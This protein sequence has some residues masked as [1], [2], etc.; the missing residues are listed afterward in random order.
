MAQDRIFEGFSHGLNLGSQLGLRGMEQQRQDAILQLQQQH[1]ARQEQ[2]ADRKAGIDAY[3]GLANILNA[4]MSKGMKSVLTKQYMTHIGEVTGKP[5]DPTV[6]DALTRG[7]DED[8]A[9]IVKGL[10]AFMSENQQV[11]AG[12][13]LDALQ[14]PQEAMKLITQ[15][16][17][18][19]NK[20]EDNARQQRAQEATEGYRQQQLS[21]QERHQR[22]ME[23]ISGGHLSVAQ[24]NLALR[25][26]EAAASIGAAKS[27]NPAERFA[28]EMFD[29]PYGKL[30]QD[31]RAQVNERLRQE[32]LELARE[33]GA[34]E[35]GN[36]P[37][38]A[39]QAEELAGVQGNIDLLGKI[40]SM[41][42]PGFVGPIRGRLAT[43]GETAGVGLSDAELDFRTNMDTYTN[44]L[45]NLRAGSAQSVQ[46]IARLKREA[47]QATDTPEKLRSKLKASKEIWGN[48]LQRR[49]ESLK[50]SG[51]GQVPAFQP[52]QT[53]A[54]TGGGEAPAP[55][56]RFNPAT[57][58]VEKVK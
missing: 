43:V 9:M 58:K 37:L 51:Y 45:T 24:A 57:G 40:E 21:Q 1:Q 39:Q 17:E 10:G 54:A 38:P 5:I 41:F 46:E 34:I 29:A 18:I 52:S 23:G 6:I 31:Q 20:R 7:D 26:Q 30:D 44:M 33:K 48:I 2:I 28:G 22:T 47:P 55:T 49:S 19:A 25:R 50:G 42:D 13:L 27:T 15:G 4:K 36:R 3:A 35:A 11:G 12:L 8:H 16:V 32:M 56:H 14:D 53:P